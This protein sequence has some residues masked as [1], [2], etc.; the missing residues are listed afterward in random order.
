M[1]NQMTFMQNRITFMQNQMAAMQRRLDSY[2]RFMEM[3]QQQHLVVVSAMRDLLRPAEYDL[4]RWII[5]L[6]E[7]NKELIRRL[8]E[9]TADIPPVP[10]T[11]SFLSPQQL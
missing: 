6:S 3:I 4:S 10:D 5:T 8:R 11:A 2:D 1:R 7:Y 9:Y